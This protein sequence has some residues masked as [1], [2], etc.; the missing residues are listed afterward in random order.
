MIRTNYDWMV[1]RDALQEVSL[2]F[3]AD[4]IKLS[5]NEIGLFEIKDIDL[6]ASKL[7]GVSGTN[8]IANA[9]F[10]EI[11]R[12][13]IAE[14][15]YILQTCQYNGMGLSSVVVDRSDSWDNDIFSV[16]KA[17][18]HFHSYRVTSAGDL[19]LYIGTDEGWEYDKTY[20]SSPLV[21]FGTVYNG[22]YDYSQGKY[23]EQGEE[24]KNH[25]EI[26]DKRQGELIKALRDLRQVFRLKGK[27]GFAKQLEKLIILASILELHLVK[28]EGNSKGLHIAEYSF[29]DDVKGC[30][31]NHR[32][33]MVYDK[34]LVDESNINE[35]KWHK[36]IV[37]LQ[38]KVNKTTLDDLFLLYNLFLD[39]VNMETDTTD[40]LWSIYNGE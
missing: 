12:S 35:S 5:N 22:V 34:V 11:H 15:E 16:Y 38:S 7:A 4:E 2:V 28:T 13:C 1:A 17:W 9:A 37:K 6:K 3:G 30:Y 33:E 40:W 31:R 39:A 19:R 26:V 25:E 23:L 24:P 36:D 8:M 20:E 10:I 21:M 29:Y 27:G 14:I 32:I 18:N